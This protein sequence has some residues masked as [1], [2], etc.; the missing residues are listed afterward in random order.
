MT[1]NPHRGHECRLTGC[2]YELY[3]P[4]GSQRCMQLAYQPLWDDCQGPSFQCQEPLWQPEPLLVSCP[5]STLFPS[6]QKTPAPEN[7]PRYGRLLATNKKNC[8]CRIWVPL[9][10][11]GS[12]CF[13]LQTKLLDPFLH[14]CVW[15]GVWTVPLAKE[16]FVE[17]WGGGHIWC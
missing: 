16:T 17:Q 9:A 11:V 15:V 2:S 4:K 6:P 12:C 7:T 5:A 8:S 3:P 10:S 13:G 1:S 14:L